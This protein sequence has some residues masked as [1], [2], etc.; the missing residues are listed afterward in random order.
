MK[1]IIVYIACACALISCAKEVK[2]AAEQSVENCIVITAVSSKTGFDGTDASGNHKVS[3]S[4][5]DVITVF[6]EDGTA[7]VSEGC[8]AGA[9]A[10]F[11]VNNF[12]VGKTPKY[13]VFSGTAPSD[14]YSAGKINTVA[15]GTQTIASDDNFASDA[16]I[17]TGII[18]SGDQGYTLEMKNVMGLVKVRVGEDKISSIRI[19]GAASDVLA[20]PVAVVP[21]AT[22]SATGSAAVNSVTINYKS[23]SADTFTKG[24]D[25]YFCVLPGTITKPTITLT[26]TFGHVAK[27]ARAED[28]I[29]KRGEISYV[30]ELTNLVWDLNTEG[31]ANCYPIFQAGTYRFTPT[32]GCSST[33]IEGI[34]SMEILWETADTKDAPAANAVIKEVKY[35]NGYVVFSTP[36]TKKSG[37]ALIAAKDA[38]GKILWSWHIWVNDSKIGV[39]EWKSGM[40]LM[41]RNLGDFKN[42]GTPRS[43]M[44]YQWGRKDPF[45]AGRGD[46][47]MIGVQG[48]ATTGAND[49]GTYEKSILNP[50]V[51]YGKLSDAS[52]GAQ[53]CWQ[54]DNDRW[55]NNGEKTIDDPCPVG[56]KVPSAWETYP[57][58][59]SIANSRFSELVEKPTWQT[60]SSGVH[61]ANSFDL[62][63][64]NGTL[65][66]FAKTCF[67]RVNTKKSDCAN[68]SYTPK[69]DGTAF[70]LWTS[71]QCGKDSPAK[72]RAVVIRNTNASGATIWADTS[73]DTSYCAKNNAYAVRC[74]LIKTGTKASSESLSKEAINW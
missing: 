23:S 68:A 26:T 59:I 71:T 67:I 9:A 1:K 20:G 5:G 32:K 49:Q 70:Y 22:P 3:W 6:D 11:T 8:T 73:D 53:A 65:I 47:N 52:N 4:E 42:T 51:L 25:Y 46:S 62:T 19:A 40:I 66:R 29:V 50:T 18:E 16:A 45:P 30:G 44:L 17:S 31:T 7:Y 21:S 35:E 27:V 14:T 36:A 10:K 63:L 60:S 43:S 74:E 48:T 56:Y 13:A 41:D 24:K 12:P 54:S 57:S 2:P 28:V 64:E 69:Y 37:N 58:T 72:R 61:Y 34:S 39:H 38:G 55:G 15:K 33:P